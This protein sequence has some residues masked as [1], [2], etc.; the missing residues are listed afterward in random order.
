MK[1]LHLITTLEPG[2][3]ENQLLILARSQVRNGQYVKVAYLKGAGSLSAKFID[4]GCEVIGGSGP[5]KLLLLIRKLVVSFNPDVIHTHLPRAEILAFLLCPSRL[6]FNSRH[7]A[8]AFWPRGL[9]FMSRFLSK[10][11]TGRSNTVI[12]ISQGVKDFLIANR[13]VRNPEKI[14]VVY[15]GFDDVMK[16]NSPR[17]FPKSKEFRFLCVARL[18]EQKDIATLL[19]A[20]ALQ[21]FERPG[22][23]LSIVGSGKLES[24]L[25]SIAKELGISNS[26]SWLGRLAEVRPI[27][28]SH[29]C[30]ILPSKYEGFGLV[31]LEA[32]QVGIPILAT[33]HPVILEVLS[34]DHPGIFEI[35]NSLQLAYLMNN[36]QNSINYLKNSHYSA[37][38]VQ[39]F[40]PEI[41]YKKLQKLYSRSTL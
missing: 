31:L 29:D 20:F 17:S 1:I 8:E 39:M 37:S 41:Q 35:G 15:Y 16:T 4:M 18:E 22:A 30:L 33:S 25:K 9:P 26:V 7:N 2:G 13:E 36:I 27:Y 3:A 10:V 40:H 12:A 38:R 32:A 5:L 23:K 11:V 24:E 19:K 6:I 34:P 21:H 14:A 28:E